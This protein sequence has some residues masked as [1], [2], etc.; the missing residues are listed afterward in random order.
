MS[1]L[2][3]LDRARPDVDYQADVDA[4]ADRF[5]AAVEALSGHRDDL[6]VVDQLIVVLVDQFHKVEAETDDDDPEHSP[7]QFA[8]QVAAGELGDQAQDAWL[9]SRW[10]LVVAVLR[11]VSPRLAGSFLDA[12]ANSST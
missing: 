12:D 4:A 5:R 11:D 8:S 9:A 10:L 7:G 1:G 2:I 3:A 6:G